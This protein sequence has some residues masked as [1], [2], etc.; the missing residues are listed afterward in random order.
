M[1]RALLDDP[2]NEMVLHVDVFRA[3]VVL[4][5]THERDC[6]LVVRE[7]GGGHGKWSED[8]RQEAPKP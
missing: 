4:M 1:K 2:V 8:L 5:I 7:K 6:C 3:C